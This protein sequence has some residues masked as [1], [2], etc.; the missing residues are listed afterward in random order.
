MKVLS[1]TEVLVG[2]FGQRHAPKLSSFRNIHEVLE[3]SGNKPEL[4]KTLNYDNKPGR[5]TKNSLIIASRAE[6]LALVQ[7]TMEQKGELKNFIKLLEGFEDARLIS[8]EFKEAAHDFSMEKFGSY[9]EK[10]KD[11]Q[12]KLTVENAI[13]HS[14]ALFSTFKRKL[15]G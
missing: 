11:I 15:V 12:P 13:N 14:E 6:E 2:S 7:N 4:Q 8:S 9:L 5:H 1:N 10:Y 3:G